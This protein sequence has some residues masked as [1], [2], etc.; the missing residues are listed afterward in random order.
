MPL[1][2]SLQDYAPRLADLA[3]GHPLLLKSSRVLVRGDQAALR[4]EASSFSVAVIGS[5]R[6]TTY[7]LRFVEEF[8]RFAAPLGWSFVSGGALGID[9][10]VHRRALVSGAPTRAWVV[11]P[12]ERP[13]PSSHCALFGSLEE[14]AGC[15]VLC[16]EHLEGRLGVAAEPRAWVDRN[17][18]VAADADAV[19]VVEA[20]V[21]SGTW[22]T[23]K[24]AADL[25][26]PVYALPGSVFSKVSQGTNRMI[27]EGYALQIEG[28]RELTESL[29]VHARPRSY[30]I[31][32][33]PAKEAKI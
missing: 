26:R 12:I 20:Q 32:R 30:N 19:V 15:A 29:V 24:I 2:L 31:Y 27:A 23:A 22:S 13:S 33:G 11:G 21:N 6:P 7:G 28:V 16:P 1:S 3:R 18:W 8:I 14:R 4:A 9:A 10:A 5:R 17:A 25:G